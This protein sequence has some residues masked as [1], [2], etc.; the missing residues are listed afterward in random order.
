MIDEATAAQTLF[1]GTSP[2]PPATQA[3]ATPPVNAKAEPVADPAARMFGGAEQPE[4]QNASP[5]PAREPRTE[6]ELAEATYGKEEVLPDLAPPEIKA[7]RDADPLRKVYSA[8]VQYRDIIP[9]TALDDDADAA[10]LPAE[11]RKAL[12][13]ESREMAADLGMT[14]DDI[15]IFRAVGASIKEQPPTD[16]QCIEWQDQA[17]DLLN[18]EFGQGAKQALRDARKFAQKDKRLSM[19]LDR[20]GFGDHPKIVLTVA[21]LAAKAKANSR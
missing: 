19:A 12:I 18:A 8:Q 16:E 5:A 17:I 6:D 9:D 10:D 7:E 1:G 20:N 4:F 2:V 14:K 15:E 13:V 21:R 3:P 11:V